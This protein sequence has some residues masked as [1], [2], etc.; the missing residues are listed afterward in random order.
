MNFV[1]TRGAPA[2][3]TAMLL[4]LAP[5]LNT[6]LA[7]EAPTARSPGRLP[8]PRVTAIRPDT[9]VVS[10]SSNSITVVGT[11]PMQTR[12]NTFPFATNLVIRM[13]KPGHRSDLKESEWVTA[14]RAPAPVSPEGMG[15]SRI[16]ISL[17]TKPPAANDARPLPPPPLR[18]CASG[19]LHLQGTN[20]TLEVGTMTV[21]LVFNASTRVYNSLP[22]KLEDIKPDARILLDF[23]IDGGN[24]RATTI[25][26]LPQGEPI[27]DTPLPH[28]VP[29]RPLRMPK[30]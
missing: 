6:A 22:G 24:F 30:N 7:Q 3:A 8:G 18:V 12:E 29:E 19:L 15:V 10:V 14:Y 28:P 21:P 23:R 25:D 20:A 17:Q 5:L 13:L 27:P 26:I 2:F 4:G 16:I 1:T 9:T 11:G